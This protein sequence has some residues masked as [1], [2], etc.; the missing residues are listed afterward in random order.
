MLSKNEQPKLQPRLLIFSYHRNIKINDYGT[1]VRHRHD[2]CMP[3]RS[4]STRL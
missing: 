4:L 2:G 3:R 1:H